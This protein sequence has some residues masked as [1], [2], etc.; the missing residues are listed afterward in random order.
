M[1]NNLYFTS[2]S[3]KEEQKAFQA[4]NN[5][6]ESIGYYSLPDQ[7][8]SSILEY[9]NTISKDVETI[10]VIGI[11]GSSLG[12]KAVYEFMKPVKELPRKLYFFESTDPINITDLLSKFDVKKT[13]FLV[14]SK[15]GSTVETFSIYKYI[16]SLQSDA[17]AYT[18]ITDPDSPLEKYAK[19]IKASVLH[20][21]DNVGGRFSVLSTVGLVPLAMC[22]IDINSLLAG[23]RSIKNSFFEH[24]Y[25]RDILL[26][27][28]VYYAKNHAQYNINCIFAYSE[29]LKYFCQ[30][31]VQLWGESLGK[32]QRHSAFHVGLT[33]IGLIGP[34]D[35]HSFLQLIM[36]G[37]R[38]K[39]V[40][41]IKIEDFHDDTTIP[42]IT[43]PNLEMLDSL[44][45]LP[46]SK[47]INMQCD[48]VIEALLDQKSIP[49]DTITIQS[50]TE[51]NIGSLMFYYE[52][53]TS[54]VGELIDVNTYD[55]P[56][57]E[58]GKIILKSKLQEL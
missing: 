51:D 26:N 32:H 11:G 47:L 42:D 30:W 48:S 12:A 21:P 5:E 1:K 18:F 35:Q 34:K 36:E 9:C 22:G 52:L 43:L 50:V 33:P 15:S 29:T 40:T 10:A 7:D 44:N 56:G 37:T 45:N 46:F 19:E 55:Q 24:G 38:D 3:R 17:S 27:K 16:Y 53:L 39:S 25:I 20:L 23:A 4:I 28:A 54:L 41:F 58:A 6:Q 14:I 31:Y 8:I 49:L 2:N 57:V 13:H